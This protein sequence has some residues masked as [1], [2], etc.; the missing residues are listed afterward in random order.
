M[1]GRT[2]FA[3]I[4]PKD[5]FMAG[6]I[7][8]EER[9]GPILLLLEA[10]QFERLNLFYT[11]AM[12]PHA[13]S[14]RRELAHRYPDCDL[15]LELVPVA[16]P[17]DYSALMGSLARQ[18]R[19]LTASQ[20][21]G[22]NFVCVSSGTAEMRAIWFLIT[23][24]G[25]LPA[26]LLQ[27]GS[28]AEPLFGGAHVKEVRF[29]S[30][31]WSSLRDLVMPLQFFQASSSPPPRT[32][33]RKLHEHGAPLFSVGQA[34]MRVDAPARADA[35]SPELDNALQ[36]LG[37]FIA[38]AVLRD[39]AERSAI[40]ADSD[41]PVL[42]L[43]E[44][45]TGKELFAR[46]IHRL[47]GRR[48]R[49]LIAVN[50]AAMP[51]EL[52]ESHLFGHVRGAFTGAG[53]DQKG[54]FE[55][56][57]GSTLFLDE[58]GELPLEAQAKLLRIVQDGMLEPVGSGKARHVDVRIVAATNRNLAQEVAAGCFREDLYYRLEV[59]QVRLPPLRDRPG[60]IAMLATALLKQI[61][62]RRLHP[63]KLSK[64][65]LRRLE[66]HSWPGNVRELSNV[67]HRSVLY[68]RTEVLGP[69]DLMIAGKPDGPDP[70]SALP[71]PAPGFSLEAFLASARKQL[72]L[73]ALEKAAGN[74]STAAELLG[75]S[76]Q[77]ISRFVK[78]ESDNSA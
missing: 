51:K 49:P 21:P 77:A 17:K 28:P 13:E 55:Q 30:A 62:Q 46:L 2:L 43:G 18:V 34:V 53:A 63:R 7:A 25:I 11:P 74:Q 71:E 78:Q 48:Q 59:V 76:K 50:C 3:F 65:A 68:S 52:V 64:D 44:T 54:K 16:D 40:A 42:F 27:V 56:A 35:A 36:E 61:N 66:L 73:R 29:D 70:M 58:I 31:D 10:R 32:P 72:I 47:S 57:D 60:E 41:Y 75:M 23:A 1:A 22:Q 4:D 45:G 19:E 9:P 67:L 33:R 6:E 69:D 26:T 14:T 38:S 5:P 24:A 15:A 20:P 37:I 39:A 12:S 8:G